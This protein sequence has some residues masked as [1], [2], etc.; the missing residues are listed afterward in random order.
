[1]RSTKLLVTSGVQ[2]TI[3]IVLLSAVGVVD[4]N[5]TQVLA[6]HSSPFPATDALTSGN[7]ASNMTTQ[8]FLQQGI[9]TSS[10]ARQNETGQIAVILPFRPDGKAYTGTLTFSASRPVE[11][12][13]VQRLPVDNATLSQIDFQ[14]YGIL[15]HWI[16]NI[17]GQHNLD[18]QTALQ[19]ITSIVPDYGISTPF[20]SASIPFV[21]HG[22]TLW[23]CSTNLSGEPF[24]AGY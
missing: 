18:N 6:Q 2:A 10:Q 8:E 12:G 15:S 23:C 20:F 22:V 3:L 9:V 1:L 16:R 24:I 11:V 14:K 4:H 5:K 17:P 7:S 19:I 21:A 13:F